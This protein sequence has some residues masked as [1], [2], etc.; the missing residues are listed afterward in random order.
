MQV[1]AASDARS[2]P[3]RPVIF[4]AEDFFKLLIAQLRHQDPMKPMEDREFI[5]QTAQFSQLE[6]VRKS[7]EILQAMLGVA[8]GDRNPMLEAAPVIG[9]WARGYVSGEEISGVV[10]AVRQ[11]KDGV[12]FVIEGTLVR[13]YE[14]V[15]IRQEV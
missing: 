13:P 9:K 8:L 14:I 7:N 12:C 5:A 1:N 10:T 4:Q 15:E 2:A 6:E 11:I 3:V